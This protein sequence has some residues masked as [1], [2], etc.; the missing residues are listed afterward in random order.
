MKNFKKHERNEKQIQ[1]VTATMDLEGTNNDSIVNEP[2]DGTVD[3]VHPDN[4]SSIDPAQVEPM[5]EKVEK[6]DKP[7]MMVTAAKLNI[8]KDP[9]VTPANVI[10]VVPHGTV[11]VEIEAKGEWTH[12]ITD[13][14]LDDIVIDGYVM[15]KFIAPLKGE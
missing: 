7:K 3:V 10:A 6:I 4:V 1:G 15:T 9:S 11:L 5:D 14:V 2:L 12:V 13:T 8:R